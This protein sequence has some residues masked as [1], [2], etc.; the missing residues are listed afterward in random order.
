MSSTG[1]EK[2]DDK[3]NI[4]YW[5]RKEGLITYNELEYESEEEY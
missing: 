2:T 4:Y 3:L 5:V 1:K